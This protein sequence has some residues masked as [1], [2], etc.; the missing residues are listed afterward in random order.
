MDKICFAIYDDGKGN[1]LICAHEKDYDG[2]GSYIGIDFVDFEKA[3]S[4]KK[5]EMINDMI[6]AVTK[7][8]EVKRGI[9]FSDY[10]RQ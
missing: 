4:Q 5:I 3:D 8:V 1:R 2:D 7:A 9:K 6:V 10:H